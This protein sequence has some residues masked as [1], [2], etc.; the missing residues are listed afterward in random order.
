MPTLVGRSLKV[1]VG[2]EPNDILGLVIPEGAGRVS[3]AIQA[4]GHHLAVDVAA[5]AV[6]RAQQVI[7]SGDAFVGIQGK[8]EG[9]RIADAGLIAQLKTPKAEPVAA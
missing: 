2:V 5:K 8:I 9:M 4:G 3:F 1:S 6:R 7:R